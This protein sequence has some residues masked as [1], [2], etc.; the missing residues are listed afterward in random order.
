MDTFA[1]RLKAVMLANG[2]DTAAQL[3]AR[4]KLSLRTAKRFMLM[5][6]ADRQTLDMLALCNG[7]GVRFQY[8]AGGHF[9]T[10]PVIPRSPHIAAALAV[11]D[12]LPEKKIKFWLGV[13]RRL[14]R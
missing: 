9:P 8:L 2:M 14:A 13:G 11:L 5:V 10:E 1:Q 7:L 12:A 6:A 4:C 3:A